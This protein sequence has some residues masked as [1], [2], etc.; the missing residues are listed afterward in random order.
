MAEQ[1]YA[2]S[3]QWRRVE[4]SAPSCVYDSCIIELRCRLEALEA[5]SRPSPDPGQIRSSQA[6]PTGLVESVRHAIDSSSVE[7]EPRAAIRAVAAW[8]RKHDWIEA[9]LALE[10]EAGSRPTSNDLQLGSLLTLEPL[11]EQIAEQV[12]G[13]MFCA[14]VNEGRRH[15]PA[16]IPDWTPGGNSLMQD[17]ARVT[18]RRILQGVAAWLEARTGT[19]ANGSQWADR[20]RQEANR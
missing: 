17:H 11:A 7:Q 5:N 4:D 19:I 1:H 3:E 6:E 18:A 16:D 8:L 15:P 13:A 20:L 2:T 12:Y 9:P 10:K 14:A